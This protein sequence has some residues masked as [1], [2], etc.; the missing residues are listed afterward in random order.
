ML[1]FIGSVEKTGKTTQTSPASIA[2]TLLKANHMPGAQFIS[3][4]DI[5]MSA[6]LSTTLI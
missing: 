1:H 2:N 6:C 5:F 3:S 4:R